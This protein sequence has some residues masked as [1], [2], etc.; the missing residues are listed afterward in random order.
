MTDPT[1]LL[2]ET[3]DVNPVV[4]RRP[5]DITNQPLLALTNERLGNAYAALNK[6]PEANIST[7]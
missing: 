2:A 1:Q 6:L 5:D 7:S 4:A 3:F